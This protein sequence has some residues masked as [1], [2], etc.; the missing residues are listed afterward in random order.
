[1]RRLLRGPLRTLIRIL[2]GTAPGLRLLNALHRRMSPATHRRFFYLCADGTY[3]ATGEWTVD[4]AGRRLTLPLSRDFP[5]GWPL[6][7]AFHGHDPELHALYETLVRGPR[8]PRVVFDVGANYGLHAVRFL[9]HGARVIAFE[10][11]PQCHAW[12]RA[13][14]AANGVRCE[15]EP[16]AVG[17]GAD[18]VVLAVPEGR[19]YMGTVVPTVQEAWREATVRTTTVRQVALD[20]VV[21]ELGTVPDLI[22]ID[23]EG[24]EIGVL[25]GAADLLRTAQPTLVFEAWPTAEA[26][27]ELWSIL[28]KHGYVI[29]ALDDFVPRRLTRDSFMTSQATNFLAEVPPGRVIHSARQ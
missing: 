19:T 7:I 27:R 28:D 5:D 24:A 25:R 14:C 12:F 11:N 26:R 3:P 9:A 4:F 10:P 23:T 1:M 18:T 13:L 17:E 22:K 8:P 15:L 6:G 2:V 29:A 16:V 21:A 20:D